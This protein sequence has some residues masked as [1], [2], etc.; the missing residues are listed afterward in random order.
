MR[1]VA[2]N[3]IIEIIKCS[4]YRMSLPQPLLRY[5]QRSLEEKKQL[6]LIEYLCHP[7]EYYLLTLM[8]SEYDYNLKALA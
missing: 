4:S 1:L 2:S 8:Q 5:P 6:L 3:C 7:S